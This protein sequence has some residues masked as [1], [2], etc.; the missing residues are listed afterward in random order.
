M[1]RLRCLLSRVGLAFALM[2]IVSPAVLFFV[3]MLSLS[4]KFEVD[5]ASYPP[6]FIPAHFNWGNYAAVIDSKRFST[7]FRT[8]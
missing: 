7:Y 3:W 6:I 5:N 4:V 2:V 8:A 1:S